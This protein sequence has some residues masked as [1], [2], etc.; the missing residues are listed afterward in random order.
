[1]L[2]FALAPIGTSN[3]RRQGKSLYA[4]VRIADRGPFWFDI[5]TGA[6]HTV[7][8]TSLARELG[9]K[10]IGMTSSGGTGEGKVPVE[11]LA[12]V[13]MSIGSVKLKVA[14]PW[15]IDL[16]HVGN[17]KWMRGLVGIEFLEAFVVQIDPNTATVRFFDPG[18]FEKP[19]GAVAL[20]IED[21]NHR[22]F[23]SV[24]I[25]VNESETVTRRVR[26]DT[27]SD[28]SVGDES[29]AR[30]H[31]VRSTTL[32]HGLG[33]NYQSVSGVFDAVHIGPF[34]IRHV[35]GPGNRFPEIGMEML[36]RFTMTFDVPHHTLYLQPNVHFDEPIP[37]PR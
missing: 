37:A 24:T 10:P 33:S 25:D 4:P 30:A 20:P 29:A 7:L 27:G 2:F 22:L 9:L 18:K 11:R 17:P 23:M 5:D 28:D 32:G 1:M 16:S 36:R 19:R 34:T 12:P 6:Y 21:V 13:D 3:G 31:N 8:D 26:I 15:A 14:E 35:W